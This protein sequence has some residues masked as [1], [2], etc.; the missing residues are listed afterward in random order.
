MFTIEK[1]L[2]TNEPVQ[3]KLMLFKGQLYLLSMEN[4]ICWLPSHMCELSTPL[5]S[6][7]CSLSG[8]SPELVCIPALKLGL[9]RWFPCF[10]LGV[11]SH[12]QAILATKNDHGDIYLFIFLAWKDVHEGY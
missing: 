12:Q 7:R 3:F 9:Q 10:T 5:A 4:N 8:A 11:R 2:R 6:E 1:N